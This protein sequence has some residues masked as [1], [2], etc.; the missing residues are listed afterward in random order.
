MQVQE[1]VQLFS[2]DEIGNEVANYLVENGFATEQ[3]ID[4]E[5]HI[6]VSLESFSAI[7]NAIISD[8]ERW[9]SS[10]WNE[11]VENTQDISDMSTLIMILFKL[12]V[13]LKIITDGKVDFCSTLW[14]LFED[15]NGHRSTNK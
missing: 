1:N 6:R 14:Y 10:L 5:K 4:G 9:C 12:H 7:S 11:F 8:P 2:V 13:N 3:L 15:E